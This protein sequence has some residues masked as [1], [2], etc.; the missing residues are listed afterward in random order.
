MP[1]LLEGRNGSTLPPGGG[2][3]GGC[4]LRSRGS[5]SERSAASLRTPAGRQLRDGT[6]AELRTLPSVEALPLPESSL[7]QQLR[8]TGAGGSNI[9]SSNGVGSTASAPASEMRAA[10][11]N[12]GLS[13]SQRQLEHLREQPA[14]S[15]AAAMDAEDAVASNGASSGSEK[16][17]LAVG[18]HHHHQQQQQQ[19]VTDTVSDVARTD[20]GRIV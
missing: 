14:S 3:V 18:K 16:V 20:I 2:D 13:T 12:P 4:G 9:D 10:A 8:P 11:V 5:S 19:Q 6:P 17:A 1:P 15:A 7:S